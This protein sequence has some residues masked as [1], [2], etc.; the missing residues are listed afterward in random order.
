MEQIWLLLVAIGVAVLLLFLFFGRKRGATPVR[1]AAKVQRAEPVVTASRPAVV[2]PEK[3]APKTFYR[4]EPVEQANYLDITEDSTIG[5]DFYT[6]VASLLKQVL[7][8]NPERQDLRLK[9][10][11]VYF[12]SG[13]RDAFVQEAALYRDKLGNKND[14]SWKTVLEKGV[15]LAPEHELFASS[16]REAAK[17]ASSAEKAVDDAEKKAFRRFG[18]VPEARA[19]LKALAEAY[20]KL[21]SQGQFYM[22]LDRELIRTAG[23]P[24]QL[25]QLQRLSRETGGAQIFV[26]RED[27]AGRYPRMRVHLMGQAW[28]AK[29]LGMQ[30]VIYAANGGEE[31]VLAAQAAARAG[32]KSTIFI[33]MQRGQYREIHRQHCELMGAE[34]KETM[35]G[36][37]S[38]DIRYAALEAWLAEP[39]GRFMMLN[40][41]AGPHPYPTLTSDLQAVIGRECLRQVSGRT[42]HAPKAIFAR[43]GSNTDAIGF[44]EPFLSQKD[45]EIHLVSTLDSADGADDALAED[46]NVYQTLYS[47]SQV[48][49]AMSVLEGMEFP[50]VEREHAL[51]KSTGRITYGASRLGEA[52]KIIAQAAKL[53]GLIVPIETAHVLA[54]A[55]IQARKLSNNDAVVVM[56]AEHIGKEMVTIAVE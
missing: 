24:A 8:E 4:E 37:E 45:T 55:C 6:E 3:P 11:D 31:A 54:S 52:R 19:P 23:R 20:Q 29:R 49:S 34:I 10:L 14:P 27:L 26:K 48:R 12:D 35:A 44:V 18:D 17:P 7:T 32:L 13:N 1:T 42:G 36:H 28:I 22:Q 40:L 25:M 53:E 30:E 38:G 9:L 50:R 15:S 2:S 46:S 16:G 21:R 56:L 41:A 47:T 33:S 39:G 43:A 51:L 5:G